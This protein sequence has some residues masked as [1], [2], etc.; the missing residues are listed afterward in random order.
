MHQDL[1]APWRMA[2]LRDLERRRAEIPE[3]APVLS[4]FIAAAWAAPD[5]DDEMLVVHRTDEGLILPRPIDAPLHLRPTGR[6]SHHRAGRRPPQSLGARQ[7]VT[8]VDQRLL[9]EA[10]QE[11]VLEGLPERPGVLIARHRAAPARTGWGPGLREVT[12][13]E[14][15]EVR[16]RLRRVGSSAAGGEEEGCDEGAGECRHDRLGARGGP[17]GASRARGV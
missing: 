2:Y 1:W 6:P 15:G 14:R 8:V 13:Q 4:D 7:Q 11:R 17:S 3:G 10:V 5:R 16:A 12:P 9:N